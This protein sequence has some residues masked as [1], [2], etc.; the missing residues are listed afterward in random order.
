MPGPG[1]YLLDGLFLLEFPKVAEGDVLTKDDFFQCSKLNK[2]WTNSEWTFLTI[3]FLSVWWLLM[4][5]FP[6]CKKTCISQKQYVNQLT[7]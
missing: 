5:V 3:L 1:I 4:L 6:Y 2:W 7:L